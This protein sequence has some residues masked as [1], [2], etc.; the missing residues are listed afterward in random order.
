MDGAIHWGGQEAPVDENVKTLVST[1]LPLNCS[2]RSTWPRAVDEIRSATAIKK[3][4]KIMGSHSR[5]K[6][7]DPQSK[8][9]I[10]HNRGWVEI[11]NKF[12]SVFVGSA[13]QAHLSP[14]TTN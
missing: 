5:G 11:E 14:K 6:M 7:T 1:P 10:L 4:R 2:P 13:G 3:M 8:K 12:I 9:T